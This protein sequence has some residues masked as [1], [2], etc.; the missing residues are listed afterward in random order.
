MNVVVDLM[1][2]SSIDFS[3][4]SSLNNELSE[5]PFIRELSTLQI[6]SGVAVNP[7]GWNGHVSS[8]GG[9]LSEILISHN[10]SAIDNDQ[11]IQFKSSHQPVLSSELII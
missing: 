10:G 11:G 6:Y 1:Q 4:G 7:E 5:L 9:G 3:I 8:L 2:D